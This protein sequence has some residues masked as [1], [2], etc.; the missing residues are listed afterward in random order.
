MAFEPDGI[1][2]RL[3]SRNTENGEKKWR[4][5]VFPLSPDLRSLK[6]VI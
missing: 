5:A 4:G 2:V 1:A 6:N 3:L